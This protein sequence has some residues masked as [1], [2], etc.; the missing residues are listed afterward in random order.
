MRGDT[1]HRFSVPHDEAFGLTDPLRR[2]GLRRKNLSKSTGLRQFY[3]KE[4]FDMAGGRCQP[5]INR[6]STPQAGVLP[7]LTEKPR[8]RPLSMAAFGR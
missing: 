2:N 4:E 3:D 7:L 1:E 5:A 6:G 8:A